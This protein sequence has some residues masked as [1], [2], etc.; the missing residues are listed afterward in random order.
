MTTQTYN[1]MMT[2]DALTEI[3]AECEA[4]IDLVEPDDDSGLWALGFEA[5]MAQVKLVAQ[6]IIADCA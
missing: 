1:P 2:E 6:G 4:Y 3:V 5:A